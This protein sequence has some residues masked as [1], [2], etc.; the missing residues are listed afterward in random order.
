MKSTSKRFQEILN[1]N[2]NH[3]MQQIHENAQYEYHK[4]TVQ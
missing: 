3:M 2:W 1:A 4:E